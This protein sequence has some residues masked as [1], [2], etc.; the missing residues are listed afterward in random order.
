MKRINLL[1][2]IFFLAIGWLAIHSQA[3]ITSAG[4]GNWTNTNTWVGGVVPTSADNVIIDAG[5]IVNINNAQ[6]ECNN[7]SFNSTTSQLDMLNTNS[8]LDIYGNFTAFDATH[9]VFSNWAAGAKIKFT[10]GAATQTISGLT[11]NGA[12]AFSFMEMVVDKS[13]GTVTTGGGGM[14]I[15]IGTSLEIK[16]GTF[17][18]A[19]SDDIEGRGLT[20]SG[21][22]T[23][24]I[25]VQS[26]DSLLMSGVNSHIRSAGLS[27]DNTSKIGKMTVYGYVLLAPAQINRVNIADIDVESG[28]ELEIDNGGTNPNNFNPGTITVKSGGTFRSSKDLDYWFVNTTTPT[29]LIVQAGGE[30]DINGTTNQNFWP[31]TFTTDAGSYV[32]YSKPAQTLSTD[33]RLA[34]YSNLVLV[35]TDKTMAQDI[36]VTDT[37]F[38]RTSV[39]PVQA[40]TLSLGGFTLTYGATA[41]LVYRGIGTS[42]AAQ[43]T[44]STEWPASGNRPQNVQIYNKAN[45][46]LNESKNLSG[47]LHFRGGTGESAKLILGSFNL[48]I[49]SANNYN[50]DRYVQTTGTGKLTVSNIGTTSKVLPVGNS[51]YN[52]LVISNGSNHDWS[53]NVEDALVVSQTPFDLNV[54]YAVQ[55]TWNITPSVNPPA[56]GADI[57]FQY[58]N[59]TDVIPANFNTTNPVQVWHKETTFNYFWLAAGVSQ[60]QVDVGNNNRTATI[61][62]WNRFSP[63]AISTQDRPLPVEFVRFSGL[64]R[65]GVNALSWTTAS[66]QYN[67]GFEVQ[68]SM[69]GRLFQPV[70]YVPSRGLN[71]ASTI[72]LSYSFNDTAPPAKKYHYRLRQVALNYS[73]RFSPVI[74]LE[75]TSGALQV[76]SV[77]PNPATDHLQVMVQ[78]PADSPLRLQLI[79][80]AG[81]TIQSKQVNALAGINNFIL[82]IRKINAGIYRL[83]I[84]GNNGEI[85]ST[86]FVKQ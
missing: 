79:D 73:D 29:A 71:G 14:R 86:P 37:L 46:T 82:D 60:P 84:S 3:Q 31:Q 75:E 42:P 39:S 12:P 47:R 26:G 24:T 7:L 40:P 8:V 16:G 27:G 59:V 5:H 23:P 81:R 34:T 64:R 85:T 83:V 28:G 2:F 10:G 62:N 38:M 56:A 50:S 32:R 48:T 54:P 17:L 77:Y 35:G 76:K 63:F 19:T 41:T 33:S 43:T 70:G 52:P 15:G 78:S 36:S 55:R 21:A 22:T 65:N 53:A 45:V 57:V 13:S 51:T 18:L 68:R 69:D 6:P 72:P 61:T 66:E 11:I 25:T 80:L 44:G 49:D 58:N 4:S 74:R 67:S 30:L 9:V 20:G 1:R